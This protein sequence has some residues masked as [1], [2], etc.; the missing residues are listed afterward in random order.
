VAI[1]HED[2]LTP[3]PAFGDNARMHT[4]RQS[5]Q[6]VLECQSL[7]AADFEWPALF[8]SASGCT[9]RDSCGNEYL[10]FTS[11][12]GVV[13]AGWG[14]PAITEALR[15][16][17]ERA[18][19]APP[20]AATREAMALAGKLL[21]LLGP[22]ADRYTCLRATGGGDA[23]EAV[24]R[25]I[26]HA[27]GRERLR[28]LTLGRA[29]HGGGALPLALSD[30]KGM[31]LP[32]LSGDHVRVGPPYCLRCPW[33]L[34]RETCGLAC[35]AAVEQAIDASD[36]ID[37]VV[38]EPVLGAGGAIV[39]P[40]GYLER[41]AG[42]AH[43]RGILLIVDEVMTGFGRTGAMLAHAEQGIQPDAIILGKGLSSGY[44]PVGAALIKRDLCRPG[45]Q[46]VSST[47]AWTPLAC[48]A[49]LANIEV[50]QNED[51]CSAAER[52]GETLLRSLAEQ[53]APVLGPHCGEIRGRGLMIAIEVVQS[54]ASF[55]PAPR[56]AQRIAYQAHRLGLLV[57]LAWTPHIIMIMPPLRITV[58]ELIRGVQ[59]LASAGR[60]ACA[61]RD[62]ATAKPTHDGDPERWGDFARLHSSI[63]QPERPPH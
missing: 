42:A 38:V 10:D 31:P 60:R 15:R 30:R 11:G 45:L 49:A 29:Y 27:T 34:S 58:E 62:P 36:R 43:R 48:A 55:Q 18:C 19:F 4:P 53:V 3:A 5:R 14:H 40:R 52:A 51:L 2:R 13:N 1:G 16:Q 25:V 24:L 44:A 7:I 35:A 63:G 54:R 28:L 61:A 50:I 39:P 9:V 17:I 32:Q 26:R 21:A 41:V 47:F 23:L 8:E 59:L 33:Q 22:S 57:A 6:S 12:Y 46:D 20:W 56:L 37:A